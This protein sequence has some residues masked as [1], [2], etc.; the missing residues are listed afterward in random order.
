MEE[1]A[2]IRIQR[3]FR[4]LQ[5]PSLLQA[6]QAASGEQKQRGLREAREEARRAPNSNPNPNPSPS[7]NRTPNPSPS[8]NR[9]P[10]PSPS[11]SPN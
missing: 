7:P 6:S 2:A 8:P 10:S 5:A 4:S 9:N 1:R 11:P 3:N